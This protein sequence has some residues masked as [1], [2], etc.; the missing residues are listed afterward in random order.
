M[1]RPMCL[2]DQRDAVLSSLYLFTAKSL[3]MFRVSPA[4]I[5]RSTQ[6]VVTATG[7]G[8]EFEEVMVKFDYKGSM[9]EQL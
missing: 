8:H 4:S 2:E 9:D 6:T 3:H 7:I 1:F 5:I